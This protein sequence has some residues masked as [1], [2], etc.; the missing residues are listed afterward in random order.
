MRVM[1]TASLSC[2]AVIGSESRRTSACI[3]TQSPRIAAHETDSAYRTFIAV[4]LRY[5]GRQIAGVNERIGSVLIP[6]GSAGAVL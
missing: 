5:P 1:A 3:Y 2:I 6:V 4:V